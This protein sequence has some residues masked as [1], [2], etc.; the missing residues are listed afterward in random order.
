MVAS[1]KGGG[2]KRWGQMLLLGVTDFAK[3]FDSP[4]FVHN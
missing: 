1:G 3:L 4:N 2:M